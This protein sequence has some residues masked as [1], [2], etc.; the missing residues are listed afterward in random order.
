MRA[1][2]KLRFWSLGFG[3][4]GWSFGGSDDDGIFVLTE[5]TNCGSDD[6][7]R[8]FLL[9]FAG[10]ALLCYGGHV[11]SYREDEVM[12]SCSSV[13]EEWVWVFVVACGERL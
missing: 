6:V 11:P 9:F 8:S 5:V 13:A 12:L 2:E 7:R 10:G 4:G 3:D 1:S